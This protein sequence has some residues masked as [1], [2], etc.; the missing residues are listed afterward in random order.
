MEALLRDQ[1]GKIRELED[2]VT[3]LK[4]KENVAFLSKNISPNKAKASM[5][6]SSITGTSFVSTDGGEMY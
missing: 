3:L 5:I 6:G 2:Q 1:R 4:H